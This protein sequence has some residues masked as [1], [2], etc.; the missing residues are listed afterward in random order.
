MI[1]INAKANTPQAMSMVIR[2]RTNSMTA[3]TPAT[4][5]KA[6]NRAPMDGSYPNDVRR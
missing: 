3:M 5:A 1:G 6:S 4:M 2:D